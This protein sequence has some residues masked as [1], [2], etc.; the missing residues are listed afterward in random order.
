MNEE[1]RQKTEFEKQNWKSEITTV[2]RK[3]RLTEYSSHIKNTTD[4]KSTGE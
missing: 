4:K 1:R 3:K 2:E